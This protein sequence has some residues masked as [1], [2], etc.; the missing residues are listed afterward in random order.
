[1]VNMCG[2]PSKPL[3][4]RALYAWM[5]PP[6]STKAVLATSSAT[7]LDTHTPNTSPKPHFNLAAQTKSIKAQCNGDAGLFT[8]VRIIRH[9]LVTDWHTVVSDGFS[10]GRSMSRQCARSFIK[11]S[12]SRCFQ[13][14]D[15][16]L[17]NTPILLIS[18]FHAD[19][20]IKQRS[21]FHADTVIKQRISELMY[22]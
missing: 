6:F 13:K 14:G 9:L 3:L 12:N 21:L 19:T 18:L 10:K 1:M 5:S 20:A 4:L 7:E 8:S 11:H 16:G 22:A 15:V 17:D 2:M